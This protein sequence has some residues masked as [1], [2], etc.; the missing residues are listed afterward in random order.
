MKWK[1]LTG[2]A[3]AF[4]AVV[5]AWGQA[6]TVE[7]APFTFPAEVG[8]KIPGSTP[9]AAPF[10]RYSGT[11]SR[12]GMLTFSWSFPAQPRNQRGAIIIYS[13]LGRVIKTFPVASNGGS[14][15]WDISRLGVKGVYIARIQCGSARHNLKLLLCR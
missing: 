7:S 14:V 11:A 9:Q 8:V 12:A 4:A 1:C 2:A 15:T 6:I 10:F 13:L 5:T 3:V